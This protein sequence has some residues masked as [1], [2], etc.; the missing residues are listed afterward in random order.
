MAEQETFA[1]AAK[2][3]EPGAS[4]ARGSRPKRAKTPPPHKPP[5][6]VEPGAPPKATKV[7]PLSLIHI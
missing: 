1:F 7:A 4:A 2:K 5:K 3:A 6:A